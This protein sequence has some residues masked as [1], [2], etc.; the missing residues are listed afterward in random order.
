MSLQ[1]YVP[2]YKKWK[3][4]KKQFNEKRVAMFERAYA[5]QQEKLAYKQEKTLVGNK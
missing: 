3:N 5:Q 4:K 1:V 2:C